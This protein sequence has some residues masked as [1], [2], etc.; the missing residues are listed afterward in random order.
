MLITWTGLES[1]SRN[2]EFFQGRERVE[3]DI[4]PS[5]CQSKGFSSPP[6]P[7]PAIVS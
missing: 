7:T 1:E 5:V 4:F 3:K 6:T 2:L